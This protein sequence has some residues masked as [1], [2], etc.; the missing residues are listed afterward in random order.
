MIKYVDILST[1]NDGTQIA[2]LRFSLDT[3]DEDQRISVK[4]LN[5]HKGDYKDLL[6]DGEFIIGKNAIKHSVEE[7]GMLFLKNLKYEFSGSMIRATD[8]KILEA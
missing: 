8:V 4:N 7:S 3:T 2:I 6:I 5:D 1:K